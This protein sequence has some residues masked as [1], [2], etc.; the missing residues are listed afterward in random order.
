[1]RDALEAVC[2]FTAALRWK[3]GQ[4]LVEGVTTTDATGVTLTKEA[5][6]AVEARVARLPSLDKC[7]VDIPYAPE[8]YG[9]RSYFRVPYTPTSHNIYVNVN[10]LSAV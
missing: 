4:P 9:M 10:L 5:R 3:D 2:G 6:A 7:C 1:M 8:I